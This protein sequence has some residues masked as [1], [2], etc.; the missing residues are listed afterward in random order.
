MKENQLSPII[1]YDFVESHD[2]WDGYP[3]V[4]SMEQDPEGE[5]CLY[6]DYEKLELALS[7]YVKQNNA[8]RIEMDE[9]RLMLEINRYG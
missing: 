2:G 5:Y 9:I 4:R 8:L 3:V 1:R 7:E 6:E